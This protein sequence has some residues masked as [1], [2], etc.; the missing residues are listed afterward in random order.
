MDICFL[1][2]WIFFKSD[3]DVFNALDIMDNKE[4][5]EKLKFGNGDGNIQYYIYNWA[6]PLIPAE[7]VCFTFAVFIY[8]FM[9]FRLGCI[10]TSIIETHT[11]GQ[12]C[13]HHLPLLF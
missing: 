3:F 7:K 2:S 5:L 6:C 12:F 4:F 9:F 10:G 11:T 1:F 8:R 13:S